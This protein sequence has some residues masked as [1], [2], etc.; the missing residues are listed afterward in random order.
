MNIV[1]WASYRHFEQVVN[2]GFQNEGGE[3]SDGMRVLGKGFPEP[4]IVSPGQY[5]VIEQN[6]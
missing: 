4:I 3:N 5:Q 1:V 2:K 6:G